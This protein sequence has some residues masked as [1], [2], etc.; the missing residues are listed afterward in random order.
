[1][2]QTFPVSPKS[3]ARR[4]ADRA[5][6]DEAAVFAILDSAIL[7]HVG[8]VIDGQPFVTPTAFWREGRTLY[9][10]GSAASRMIRKADGQP[11]CVTVS[12][13]DGLVLDRSGFH[14][15]VNYRSVMAFGTAR[16]IRDVEAR[17]K[18]FDD[19]IER[20]YPGRSKVARPA[21]KAELKQTLL[22]SMEIEEASA[23]TRAAGPSAAL[24]EDAGWN[25][26]RGVIPIE[27]RIGAAEPDADNG[28]HKGLPADLAAY[29][30][31]A[32]LDAVLSS[33]LE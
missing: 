8:Y 30:A 2:S 26:W 17:L 12:H 6:Y 27:T 20:L 1:M 19:L 9:W 15:S 29:I 22:L 31:G 14:H 16:L 23:K 33:V 13:L 3:K 5:R 18:G 10:H 21:S 24:P 11:V 4:L 25:G 32:R 28:D 7:A